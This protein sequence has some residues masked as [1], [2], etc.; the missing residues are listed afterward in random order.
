VY[1][2]YPE[3]RYPELDNLIMESKQTLELLI[4][5]REKSKIDLAY[6][7]VV[8]IGISDTFNDL[9]DFAWKKYNNRLNI[10]WGMQLSL[11]IQ[12]I[13]PNQL[14]LGETRENSIGV[15]SGVVGKM[16]IDQIFSGQQIVWEELRRCIILEAYRDNP[17]E[18]D[19]VMLK[20]NDGL[21]EFAITE[22]KPL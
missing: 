17:Y 22:I 7:A 5:S 20:S 3:Q 16:P 8:L 10:H 18:S 21:P 2:K 19:W 6:I 13:E 4:R 15:N 9:T 1:N 12:A 11:Q 14:T